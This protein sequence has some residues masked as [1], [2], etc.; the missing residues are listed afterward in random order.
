[1]TKTAVFVV[2]VLLST[3]ALAADAIVVTTTGDAGKG[4]LRQALLDANKHNGPD[5]IVF[6]RKVFAEPRT[7]ALKSPLPDLSGEL[8][9]DGYIEDR[10]WLSS[11]AV[12]SGGGKHRV[13]RVREGARVSIRSL[14]VAD[15]AA[16]EG[17]GILNEG[18]L[19]VA[20]AAFLENVA[21][22]SGGGIVNRG[23]TLTVINSTF[24]GNRAG[25]DG[26]GL[27]GLGGSVT[28]T[29]CT[30]SGNE[31]KRGG[32]LYADGELALRN[33]ILADS[34]G[35]LDCV[36]KGLA[37]PVTTRN[38]I[39]ASEGCGIPITSADPKLGSLGYYNGPTKI[40]PLGGGSPA[41]NLGDN[42]SAVDAE[43]QPLVWDQRG[44]GDPRF[45][46]GFTDIGSFEHQAF[47][48]LTVDTLDD[49]DLRAC[50]AG[51]AADCPLRGALELA[52]ATQKPDMITFDPKVFDVPRT[53]ALKR[54]L[55]AV[56]AAVVLDAEKTP[57]VVVEG[58]AGTT[59]L[60]V[61][62][63]AS[64]GLRGVEL[65]DRPVASGR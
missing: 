23:G 7:I 63:G 56:T 15:G 40:F 16:P 52:N 47:P 13:F 8:T 14:T 22:G 29:N 1:M 60:E 46:A 59:N 50:T 27:A 11:G 54:P 12:V 9:V 43:G 65:R 41:I 31:G 38:I 20:G 48:R 30:F 49:N 2:L 37:A 35:G 5:T 51:G 17:G 34:A 61:A 19:V 26:G 28:V 64:L 36:A 3:I 21:R 10:L 45:V 25:E 42:A 62:P 33:T 53:I 44:N 39:E 32:G 6:D 24:T 4:S 58:P 18:T 57:G 55:P